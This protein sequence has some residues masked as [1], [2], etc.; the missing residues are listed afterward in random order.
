MITDERCTSPSQGGDLSIVGRGR[1]RDR[2][3]VLAD[4]D[5]FLRNDFL[6]SRDEPEH[7]D[8][9]VRCARW[10]VL[11]SLPRGGITG[12]ALPSWSVRWEGGVSGMFGFFQRTQTQCIWG[13][14][15]WVMEASLRWSLPP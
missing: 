14:N 7:C 15:G 6:P 9:I 13:G 8:T 10:D 2:R 11:S 3:Q 12:P 4:F 1:N 5:G